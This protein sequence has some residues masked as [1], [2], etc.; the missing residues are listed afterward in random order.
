[1][2]R[3][4]LRE[5]RIRLGLRFASAPVLVAL[6][7]LAVHAPA[8]TFGLTDLDDRDLIVDDSVF[9]AQPSSLWRVFGRAYLHVV[10]AGHAYYRPLVS[11]SYA[12]DARWSG[13]D[14]RGYHVTNVALYAVASVLFYALVRTLEMGRAIA[15][16]AALA[17]AVHPTLTSAAA[18]IP[19]R[20]DSLLAVFS[21]AAWIMFARDA[22]RPSW[23]HKA[24]HCGFFALA[25]FTKE[26][27]VVL[28]LV[29]LAHVALARPA[30]WPHLRRL[31][32]LGAFALAWAAIVS[33]RF[34]AHFSRVVWPATQEL[35]PNLRLLVTGLGKVL[36]PVHL[37]VFAVE[38]DV[39]I[40][41]GVV[42]SL[43]LS[44][45]CF[46][47]PEVRPRIIAFAAAVFVLFLAPVILL[48]GSLVLDQRLVLPAGGVILAVAEV[49]RAMR[50]ERGVLA[51]SAIAVMGAF[52]TVTVAFQGAFRDARAFA[53]DAVDGSPHS[54]LAHF[55]LG[56][57]YQ[58][59][60]ADDRALAEYQVALALGPT[61]VANNNIAVIEM[62]QARWEA[63]E[64][65]LAR[66]IAINP[67]YGRAHYNL[68]IVLRHQG[69]MA[70]AC[71][72][73]ER[74]AACSSDDETIR[75]ERERDCGR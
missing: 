17:F 62:A 19:G 61:E 21:L 44:A 53:K 32:P 58:K 30:D 59:A 10:D 36:L 29:C 7:A 20:N 43:A 69:R 60:G 50:L 52:A 5:V 75:L 26:S 66:E 64:E 34:M 27:A 25:L 16:I 6:A 49:V 45:A 23:W 24:A 15:F 46:K 14:P 33:A 67:N 4:P 35:A 48:P 1:M 38:S 57:E 11:L 42:A 13:L 54:G 18:W 74:A 3:L 72:A 47:V 68:G 39:A 55:C 70:E 9:L 37:S 73:E 56:R 22:A 63:A 51:A 28:P 65:S 40:W 8:V 71:A 31:L 12:L 2:V 41:P